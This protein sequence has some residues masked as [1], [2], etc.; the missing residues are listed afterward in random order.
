MVRCLG[1]VA[2]VLALVAVPSLCQSGMLKHA[3][4]CV[5]QSEC[6]HEAT[7]SED[8]CGLY[9]NTRAPAGTEAAGFALASLP[10]SSAPGFI[11]RCA[12]A[13]SHAAACFDTSYPRTDSVVLRI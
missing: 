9:A 13:A 1:F 6:N 3:C 7:C 11:Q 8:P 2:V 10:T 5:P 4:D 12:T